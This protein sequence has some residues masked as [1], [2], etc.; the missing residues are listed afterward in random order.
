VGK[1]QR[2]KERLELERF[3]FSSIFS[4]LG[5]ANE[6]EETGYTGHQVAGGHSRGSV[7]LF[8]SQRNISCRLNRSSSE[9]K[10]LS[11]AIAG[12]I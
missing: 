5:F 7:L 8:V 2:T 9:Q 12:C 6:N 3:F 11:T 10:Q 4:C 1:F